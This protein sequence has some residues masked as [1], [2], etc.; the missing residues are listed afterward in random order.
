MKNLKKKAA[1]F[2]ALV[3][4]LSLLPMN[5][6]G[7]GTVTPDAQAGEAIDG[8]TA[9][10]ELP[11]LRGAV[12]TGGSFTARV[13]LTDD[14]NHAALT[15]SNPAVGSELVLPV[16]I[17]AAGAGLDNASDWEVV[18][19]RNAA[20]W[21]TISIEFAGDEIPMSA[22]GLL[23]IEIPV[24]APGWMGGANPRISIHNAARGY[25]LTE[26]RL[27][28]A[29]GEVG[30]DFIVGDAVTFGEFGTVRVPNI[31]LRESTRY[32]FMV[33]PDGTWTGEGPIFGWG[34]T[35][36]KQLRL[37]APFGYTWVAP[38][39]TNFA[40]AS[41]Y[42]FQ[43]ATA[44]RVSTPGVAPQPEWT[45]A[46][47]N[48][49][50][51]DVESGPRGLGVAGAAVGEFR[52]TGLYL[53][54]LENAPATGE[55]RID[56][57]LGVVANPGN[58]PSP[59]PTRAFTP[60]HVYRAE[61]EG[62]NQFRLMNHLVATRQPSAFDITTVGTL[63]TVMTGTGTGFNTA[64]IDIMSVAPRTWLEGNAAPV[65]I[66]VNHPG[67]EIYQVRF[68]VRNP[69]Q[70]VDWNDNYTLTIT[71]GDIPDGSNIVTPT[72]ARFTPITPGHPGA[73]NATA[74]R[75]VYVQLA[76]RVNP[77]LAGNLDTINATVSV[78]GL[79]NQTVTLPIAT[80]SAPVTVSAATVADIRIAGDVLGL[81]F[82]PPTNLANVVVTEAAAGVL[83][84]NRWIYVA[85]VPTIDGVIYADP[86]SMLTFNTNL[87]I[88]P[89]ITGDL[90]LRNG[91]RVTVFNNALVGFPNVPVFRFFVER[92]SST[93]STITFT[94][95]TIAGPFFNVPGVEFNFIV[96]GSALSHAVRPRVGMAAEPAYSGEG[97]SYFNR[98]TMPFSAV[99]AR[100]AGEAPAGEPGL[101]PGP[102]PT[103]A[104]T[105]TPQQVAFGPVALTAT[106]SNGAPIFGQGGMVNVR[107]LV[108]LM[109]GVVERQSSTPTEPGV[110]RFLAV[111]ANGE[112]ASI[113][114][115]DGGEIFVQIGGSVISPGFFGFQLI[116]G[117][118]YVPQ[119]TFQTIFGY[120]PVVEGNFLR[121]YA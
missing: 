27:I 91:E 36:T 28:L 63:P 69:G 90:S 114:I 61:G 73:F 31:T 17:S 51:L 108:E 19:F 30:V 50:I 29:T 16:D 60:L 97:E 42:T 3:M 101:T 41:N 35:T 58:L 87:N 56:I 52:L 107:G 70:G 89:H 96:G 111:A 92:E 26:T 110:S 46:G 6:F 14:W 118:W 44:Y 43:G 20:R 47:R 39:S 103:P 105:P 84:T 37:L 82:I 32:S 88:R 7:R 21:G 48:V 78:I 62:A 104:P 113:V 22:T 13:Q 109:D 10:I 23:G 102:G 9:W 57:E 119:S 12:T 8:I 106:A 83:E 55:L 86:I 115:I 85:V 81:G 15:F 71:Q 54:P 120:R 59:A 65:T 18:F 79:V 68:R 38:Y 2:L 94:A 64:T 95:N 77:E 25:L 24:E 121:L 66:E 53:A 76:V 72:M 98:V 11:Q 33:G 75:R 45:E 40:E 93:A 5:V 49:L 117:S 34:G 112:N 99:V 1:L 116:G 67:V 100:I 4:M 74:N 80:V